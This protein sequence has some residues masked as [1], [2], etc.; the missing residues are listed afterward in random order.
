MLHIGS[1]DGDYIDYPLVRCDGVSLVLFY[2]EEGGS[3]FIQ[4]DCK[5]FPEYTASR[6]S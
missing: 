5:F 3:M 6:S 1:Y 2:S 4:K